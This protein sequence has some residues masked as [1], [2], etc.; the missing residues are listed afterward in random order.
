M[1]HRTVRYAL[2]VMDFSESIPNNPRGWVI[3]KQILRSG[4]SV[5]AQYREA[6]RAKSNADFI[7][8]LEGSLQELD[9]TLYW[10][11]LIEESKLVAHQ[12]IDTLKN[13]TGQ[14]IAIFTTIVKKVKKY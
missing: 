13:E 14:L 12:H 4:T 10:L 5:G 6:R 11:E 1:R 7:S 3:S 2:G 8:K 9:E